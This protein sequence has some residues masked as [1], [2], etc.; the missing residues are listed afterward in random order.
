MTMR[1]RTYFYFLRQALISL[2]RN[3]LMSLASIGT[4]VVSLLILGMFLM[5]IA[6]LGNIVTSLESKVEV[7]VFLKDSVSN[8]EIVELK[9][10]IGKLDGVKE[11]VFV[12]KG[13][14]FQELKE[15]MGNKSKVLT[16]VESNPLP[17]SFEIK[18]KDP[19]QVSVIAKELMDFKQIEEVKYGQEV[20]EKLF[21][22]TKVLRWVGVTLIVLMTLAT[23]YI[24]VNTIRLTV[25]A[26][27]KEIK[28]M[29]LVGATDWFIRWPFLIEGILLGLVGAAIAVLLLRESY[30]LIIHRAQEALPFIPIG[31]NEAQV[32]NLSYWLLVIGALIGA[33]G[34]T[35]SLHRFLQV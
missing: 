3:G 11:I 5:M 15:K 35:I 12:S 24:I 21:T 26:R 31:G 1:T 8:E 23:I 20:V 32:A 25:F 10:T 27:R 17:N 4:M 2:T 19:A 7:T 16:A 14:A 13:E 33:I 34:S 29:K 22:L 28:I 18:A 30:A 9:E 6:S